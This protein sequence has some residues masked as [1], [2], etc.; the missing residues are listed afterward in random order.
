MAR[1]TDRMWHWVCSCGVYGKPVFR[2]TIVKSLG[3]KHLIKV[4]NRD[5]R[6][7]LSI[8]ENFG[9]LK[10]VAECLKRREKHDS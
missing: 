9:P 8:E 4:H 5:P 1:R 10:K 6:Y 2:R 3:N 7:T